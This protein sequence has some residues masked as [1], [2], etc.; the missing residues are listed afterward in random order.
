MPDNAI[1]VHNKKTKGRLSKPVVSGVLLC[2]LGAASWVQSEEALTAE[3]LEYLGE[4]EQFGD[5]WVDPYTFAE[6][7]EEMAQLGKEQ[8]PQSQQQPS[9]KQLPQQ[10]NAEQQST[11]VGGASQ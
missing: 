10:G 1:A 3:F 4:Y 2:L 9:Q 7:L 11:A 5:E 8:Q 6:N